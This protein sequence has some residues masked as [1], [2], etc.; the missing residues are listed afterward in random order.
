MINRQFYL[1]AVETV[2]FAI[3]IATLVAA[4]GILLLGG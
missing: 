3:L 4:S 2:A 1:D